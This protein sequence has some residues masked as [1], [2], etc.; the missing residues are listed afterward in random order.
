[1]NL[2]D[3]MHI[4]LKSLQ[5]REKGQ[6]TVGL[7]DGYELALNDVKQHNDWV[8]VGE[9]LPN[10]NEFVLVKEIGY[11]NQVGAAKYRDGCW[12]VHCK[13]GHV[14][15][16]TEGVTHWQPLPQPPSEVQA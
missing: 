14:A 4:T 15:C 13:D 7:S 11:F 1:M 9:S 6:Y 16:T 10:D 2:I 5:D 12:W 3:S 8:S